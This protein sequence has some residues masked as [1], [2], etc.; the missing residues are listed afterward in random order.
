MAAHL[1]PVGRLSYYLLGL[2]HTF[3]YTALIV[4]ISFPKPDR[5]TDN[6]LQFPFQLAFNQRG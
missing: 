5:L 1:D 6:S 3:R 2:W 4:I